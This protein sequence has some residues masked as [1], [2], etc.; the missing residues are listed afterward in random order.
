MLIN[1]LQD[2][3]LDRYEMMPTQ[4]RSTLVVLRKTLPDSKPIKV[5]YED[6]PSD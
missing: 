2:H 1:R 6:A 4:V 3:V 5:A